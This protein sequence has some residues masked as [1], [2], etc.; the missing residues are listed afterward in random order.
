M[1]DGRVFGQA[2]AG[3]GAERGGAGVGPDIRPP[4][5]ALTEPDVID[6]R[7]VTL[8]EQRRRSRRRHSMRAIAAQPGHLGTRTTEKHYA[9]H[10]P[11][12]VA[13]PGSLLPSLLALP[14]P[15]GP[16]TEQSRPDSGAIAT[17]SS[18]I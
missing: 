1:V 5:A 16:Q 12:D 2:A 9:H 15:A 18:V 14:P 8:F 3:V 4:A 7:R 6:M 10:S 11:S 17:R 13:V